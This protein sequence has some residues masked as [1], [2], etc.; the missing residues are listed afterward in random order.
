MSPSGDLERRGLDG[1]RRDRGARSPKSAFAAAAA[2]LMSPS[3]RMKARGMRR[4]AGGKILDRALRLGAPQRMSLGT[5][6]APM[7]S[8]STRYV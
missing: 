7:L 6:S 8:C 2:C 3:A 5:S 1:A 4:P